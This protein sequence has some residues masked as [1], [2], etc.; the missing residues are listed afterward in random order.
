MEN[1]GKFLD[2]GKNI[3]RGEFKQNR[4]VFKTFTRF[5]NLQPDMGKKGVIQALKK[6]GSLSGSSQLNKVI[7]KVMAC[8]WAFQY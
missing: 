6:W 4:S 8:F 2:G 3:E 1:Y 7:G 5:R